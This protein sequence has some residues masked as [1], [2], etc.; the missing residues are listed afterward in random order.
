MSN[1]KTWSCSWP[2]VQNVSYKEHYCLFRGLGDV[3]F[4]VNFPL[5]PFSVMAQEK[6]V[7]GERKDEE[8]KKHFAFF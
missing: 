4:I 6:S 1:A 3:G 5:T 2:F 8:K 7:N